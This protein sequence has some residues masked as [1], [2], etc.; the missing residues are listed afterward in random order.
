M[1]IKSSNFFAMLSRMK[2]IDRWGLMRNTITEN[3]A[4][5]SLDVAIIAHCLAII[6]NTY[7]G[8]N[9]NAERVAVLSLFHDA[10]EIITGDLPTPIKYFAPEIKEAY[11]NVE[12]HAKRQLTNT[13]PE[14][15]KEEYLKIMDEPKELED[16]AKNAGKNN[17][18]ISEG[19]NDEI[20][21]WRF[22]KAAD[23]LSAYIKCL[24][25]KRM[26]NKDFEKAEKST[27]KAV[28]DMKMKEVDFFI[29]VFLP[30]YSLT[31]DDQ[32]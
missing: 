23:K 22:V 26:G 9:V 10:S 28:K 25:E 19:G 11:K 16:K 15:M 27:L 18:E 6:S 17:D 13:L 5:H 3:I 31:L 29:K 20:I 12:G 30:G 24:E 21:M 7:F 14:E 2:Y 4:E 32:T 8:G 1:E